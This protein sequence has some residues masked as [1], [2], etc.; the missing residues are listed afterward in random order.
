MQT[1]I[2]KIKV[3]KY[4][5]LTVRYYNEKIHIVTYKKNV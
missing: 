1:E 3:N 5:N 4:Y 2:I